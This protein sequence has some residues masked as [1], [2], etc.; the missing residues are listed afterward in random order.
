MILA[1]ESEPRPIKTYVQ[2]LDERVGGGFKKGHVIL[3][4]GSP[5]AMKSSLTLNLA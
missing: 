3:L 1:G 2:G 4:A 5:G